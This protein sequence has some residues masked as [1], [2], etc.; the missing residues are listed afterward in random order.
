MFNYFILYDIRI[1]FSKK[2]RKGSNT[3][4]QNSD[5]EDEDENIDESDDDNDN[6]HDHE[7]KYIKPFFDFYFLFCS[8]LNLLLYVLLSLLVELVLV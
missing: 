2:K 3:S 8:I 7:G 1:N 5:N 6:D 4:G